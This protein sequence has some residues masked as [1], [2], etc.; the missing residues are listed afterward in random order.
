MP[1]STSPSELPSPAAFNLGKMEDRKRPASGAVDDAAPP[2]KRQAV[3]G[4]SRSKD[5]SA[6][7]KE[8]A[9]IEVSCLS[10]TRWSPRYRDSRMDFTRVLELLLHFFHQFPKR[11]PHPAPGQAGCRRRAGLSWL[12]PVRAR[13]IRRDDSCSTSLP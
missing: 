7:M 11:K 1:I 10:F 2:S 13:D 8:E 3:N 9:W 6:D 4:G 12:V 5:D